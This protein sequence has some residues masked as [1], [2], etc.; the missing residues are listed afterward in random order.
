MATVRIC[1]KI[2]Y[3]AGVA[4]AFAMSHGQARA[5]TPGCTAMEVAVEDQDAFTQRP[6]PVVDK[7]GK[8]NEPRGLGQQ[9]AT[10]PLVGLPLPRPRGKQRGTTDKDGD[11]ATRENAFASGQSLAD[12]CNLKIESGTKR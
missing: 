7:L 10:A 9:E 5:Q 3:V 12:Y 1:R 6:P 4:L 2:S 11:I 8:E